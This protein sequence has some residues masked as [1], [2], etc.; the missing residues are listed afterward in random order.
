MRCLLWKEWQEQRWWLLPWII[1]AVLLSALGKGICPV[2]AEPN[3][4]P[5]FTI[6]PGLAL[7]SGLAGYGSELNGNRATFLFS[8]A[9]S[10]K[11][12]LAT[13]VLLGLAAVII[14]ALASTAAS[15]I[16][17]PVL[18]RPFITPALAG[19]A[20]L[21]IGLMTGAP[22][23]LGLVC[24]IVLPGLAG[25]ILVLLA[26]AGLVVGSGYTASEVFGRH[27][28]TFVAG[29]VILLLIVILVII[30]RFGL[31]LTAGERVVRV[32]ALTLAL[33]LAG[34]LL[35]ISPFGHAVQ[36]R[37]SSSSSVQSAA[38]SPSGKFAYYAV[39]EN[40]NV[41]EIPRF[42]HHLEQRED[43]RVY[44]LPYSD[45]DPIW[46]RWLDG[47]LLLIRSYTRDPLHG[48]QGLLAVTRWTEKGLDTI[49][50]PDWNQ[51]LPDDIPIRVSP[52]RQRL[53]LVRGEY[54]LIFD[55]AANRAIAYNWQTQT[56][57]RDIDKALAPT[58]I[59]MKV[60]WW[61]SEAVI[62]YLEPEHGVRRFIDVRTLWIPAAPEATR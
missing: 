60:C 7:L 33:L 34:L 22:Y 14:T 23:L 58:D 15:A 56:L 39:N 61:E 2:V 57:V 20:F 27:S 16:S 48:A 21:M 4:S 28:F 8:R 43:K 55:L 50:L 30:T 10:W 49:S 5:W 9:I 31:T 40:Y 19:Q 25:G 62:G 51:P 42:S 36:Q 44:D 47:D 32:G 35:D 12:V 41:D 52:D 53:L 11:Q 6:I 18:Y 29:A 24:S 37:F 17:C 45:R 59:T 3:P 1:G 38:V 13:K 54:F 46:R 26:G